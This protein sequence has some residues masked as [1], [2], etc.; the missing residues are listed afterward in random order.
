MLPALEGGASRKLGDEAA[1]SARA[2]YRETLGDVGPEPLA[3]LVDQA[4]TGYEHQRQRSNLLEQRANYFLGAAGLTT[5]LVLANA[6][7]LIGK[8][9][10]DHG[11]P[12]T[13]G[14]IVLIVAS[15][16]ALMSGLRALQAMMLTFER[17]PPHAV[18][19][20]V[21]RRDLSK[22][23]VGRDYLAALLVA[24]RRTTV[25]S[26]WKV[27]RVKSARRW[28]TGVVGGI[29]GLTAIVVASGLT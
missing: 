16:C 11:W 8:D 19:R 12:L 7:L 22:D 21:D 14:A 27:G 10:L 20:I 18:T 25:V 29:A 28:F 24:Q 26:N 6:G 9:A 13:T 1:D 5:T 17:T 23:D 2:S 15:V 4:E 3:E